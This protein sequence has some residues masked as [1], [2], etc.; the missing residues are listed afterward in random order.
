MKLILAELYLNEIC[1]IKSFFVALF[2]FLFFN[3]DTYSLL[4]CNP[5]WLGWILSLC[6]LM[7]HECWVVPKATPRFV[8]LHC[9][10]ETIC[11]G[12]ILR[13]LC[14]HTSNSTFLKRFIRERPGLG[15]VKGSQLSCTKFAPR[16]LSAWSFTPRVL[17][18]KP[19]VLTD[20]FIWL[21]NS[22]L[23]NC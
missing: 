6:C 18:K 23:H 3:T 13:G 4:P 15:I 20:N 11:A 14:G 19:F 12:C 17:H 1:A 16:S 8:C 9:W 22:W 5:L 7:L 2:A 21:N 10:D